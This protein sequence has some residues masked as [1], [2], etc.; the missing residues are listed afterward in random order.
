MKKT[1]IFLS[2]LFLFLSANIYS[3]EIQEYDIYFKHYQSDIMLKLTDEEKKIVK[4][5]IDADKKDLIKVW[6]PYRL[7][8]IDKE[9]T[10]YYKTSGT[11]LAKIGNDLFIKFDKDMDFIKNYI[12]QSE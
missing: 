7:V 4:K 1:I 11:S 12:S 3:E 6:C 8:L 9:Q 5:Y 10:T 2:F